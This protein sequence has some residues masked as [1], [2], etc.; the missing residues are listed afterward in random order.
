MDTGT[1]RVIACRDLEEGLQVAPGPIGPGFV[2][3]VQVAQL[4]VGLGIVAVGLQHA[5]QGRLRSV[6][7]PESSQGVGHCLAN[8][9]DQ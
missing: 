1:H 6:V 3:E 7:V 5:D 2:H 4:E 8:C 9:S